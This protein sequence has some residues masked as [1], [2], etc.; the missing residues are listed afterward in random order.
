VPAALPAAFQ[1]FAQ[2]L[3][4]GLDVRLQV[5][6]SLVLGDRAQHLAQPL[7]ALAR[8]AR[9]AKAGFGGLVLRGE[10]GGHGG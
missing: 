7:K 6:R 10:V 5:L 2:V 9:A 3:D 8:L 1:L 4:A